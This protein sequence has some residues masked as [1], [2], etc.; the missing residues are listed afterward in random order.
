VAALLLL[1]LGTLVTLTLPYVAQLGQN[2]RYFQPLLL[3]IP[4]VLRSGKVILAM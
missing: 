2:F 3:Q 1:V 4:C